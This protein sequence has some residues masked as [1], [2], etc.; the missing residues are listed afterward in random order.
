MVHILPPSF[1]QVVWVIVITERSCLVMSLYLVCMF[2]AQQPPVGQGLL[3]HEVS[4]SH[5]TKHRSR[6]DSC[7][8]DQLVAETS[9]WQHTTLTRLRHPCHRW[10]SIPQSQQASGRRRTPSTARPLGPALYLVDI[11]LF[12]VSGQVFRPPSAVMVIKYSEA[13]KYA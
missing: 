13:N 4:R 9:T 6:W 2:F 5:S 10:D 7:T 3:I 8:R 12:L 11:V 1:Q